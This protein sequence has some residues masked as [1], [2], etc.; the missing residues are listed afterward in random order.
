LRGEANDL[1]RSLAIHMM[2]G[3]DGND[4]PRHLHRTDELLSAQ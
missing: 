3:T 4:G 2:A 1:A